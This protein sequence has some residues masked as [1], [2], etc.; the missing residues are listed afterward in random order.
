MQPGKYLAG[1]L[2]SGETV[3]LTG[4]QYI[5]SAFVLKLFPKILPV[6]AYS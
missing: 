5:L 2:Q 1:G 6:M 4:V 3:N